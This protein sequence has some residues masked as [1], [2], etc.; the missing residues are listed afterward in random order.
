MRVDDVILSRLDE[1]EEVA[2]E[3]FGMA[4]F[5]ERFGGE[6]ELDAGDGDAVNIFVLVF[7]ALGDDANIMAASAQPL[8][9]EVGG[10][11]TATAGVGRIVAA[12]E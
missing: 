8:G 5:K 10:D 2:G 6:G 12:E 4:V 7:F 1:G 9:D 11:F 3:A